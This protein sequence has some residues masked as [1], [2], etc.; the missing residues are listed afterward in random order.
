MPAQ[1]HRDFAAKDYRNIVEGFATV[2]FCENRKGWAFPGGE[3][4]RSEIIA[5]HK[6]IKLNE[7]IRELKSK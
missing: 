3:V 1:G 4:I 7:L 5:R 6:A 2:P